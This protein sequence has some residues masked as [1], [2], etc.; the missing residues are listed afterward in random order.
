MDKN[1]RDLTKYLSTPFKVLMTLVVFVVMLIAIEGIILGT[2]L[3]FV[4]REEE[5]PQKPKLTE[6]QERLWRIKNMQKRFLEDGNLHLI[7]VI[8]AEQEY[9]QREERQIEVYDVKENLLWSGKY[10]DNP[11]SY[12]RYPE[13]F[14]GRGKGI[15]RTYMQEMQMLTGSISRK[16]VVPVVGAKRRILQRWRYE[17]GGDYFVGFNSEGGKIGYAGSNGFTE[18]KSEVK[19]F[20]KFKYMT[21]WEP[22][23]SISPVLL[24][25]SAN[26]VYQIDFEKHSITTLIDVQDDEIDRIAITNWCW[27]DP[28][29]SQYRP[30]LHAR[31]V[32]GES[33]IFLRDPEERFTIQPSDKWPEC[34]MWQGHNVT[35]AALK[36]KTILRYYGS[37]LQRPPRTKRLL[38]KWWEEY[39]TKSHK[40]WT[41]LHQVDSTGK[42][43]LI[44]R[45]EWIRPP[46]VER[47][48]ERWWEQS[49]S[50]VQVYTTA[51]SPAVFNI[52]RYWFDEAGNDIRYW[53]EAHRN[54]AEII[55]DYQPARSTINWALAVVM[56]CAVFWH[57]WPRRTTK[58]KLIFWLVLVACFNLAGFLTYLALNHTTV[59]CCPSC[60]KK[61]GLQRSD[62]PACKALL[63]EP[64]RRETDLVLVGQS[65]S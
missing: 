18:T 59:I 32:K 36:E 4:K 5:T 45:F 55:R 28:E 6:A 16:L 56:M 37:E 3:L 25:Q 14:D 15:N 43:T 34:D 30:T 51:V 11:Y 21:A 1:L 54:M 29:K 62:C 53:P 7:H 23:D 9:Q 47:V 35:V 10:E 40:E 20:G 46:I 17:L 49:F 13:Y 65:N 19:P 41:E 64:K 12:L 58:V 42:L 61:R 50:K 27:I 39:R 48:I 57:A 44:R 24:W 52:W 38:G 63:Q 26:R 60:G 33:I 31:T 22:A 2:A 8:E